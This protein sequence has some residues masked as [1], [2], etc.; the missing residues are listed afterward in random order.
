MLKDE[1]KKKAKE[2]S[3]ERKKKLKGRV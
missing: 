3:I 1:K 2:D